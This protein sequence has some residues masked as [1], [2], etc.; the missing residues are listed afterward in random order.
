MKLLKGEQ[1]KK[2][3]EKQDFPQDF[4]FE[5]VISTANVAKIKIYS[6]HPVSLYSTNL[7]QFDISRSVVGE[8]HYYLNLST[9]EKRFDIEFSNGSK[10]QIVLLSYEPIEKI[11]TLLHHFFENHSQS[12][13]QIK[14][15]YQFLN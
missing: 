4:V 15:E 5:E 13:K 14:N 7:Q 8:I 9:L 2:Y 6:N 12:M 3:L 10:H 1:L 11:V